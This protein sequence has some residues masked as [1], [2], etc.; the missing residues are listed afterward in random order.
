LDDL[1][2]PR[3][4]AG[5]QAAPLPAGR[6]GEPPCAAPRGSCAVPPT[7]FA[8]GTA[9]L[10]ARYAGG[11]GFAPGPPVTKS[12]TVAKAA[13]ATGLKLSATHVPYG[14][15]RRETLT[16]RVSPQYKGTPSAK[17]T[18]WW[19]G[20]ALCTLT[21]RQATA[22]CSLSPKQLRAGSYN[23]VAKYAGDAHFNG[24]SSSAKSLTISP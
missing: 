1:P 7:R 24:S 21:L 11:A 19:R 4:C 22:A 2:I 10:T 23:L 17:V 8:R 15:E 12:F 9:K 14:Q 5:Q 20:T 16:V 18:V 6:L 3:H 13:S